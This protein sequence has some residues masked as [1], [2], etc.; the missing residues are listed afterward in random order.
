M[1]VIGTVALIL[2]TLNSLVLVVA[3]REI[4]I[5]RASGGRGR[6]GL[7]LNDLVPEFATST[8]GGAP[9][10]AK[11]V[12]N[13]VLL[14]LSAQCNACMKLVEQIRAVPDDARPHGLVVGVT[15]RTSAAS[16]SPLVRSLDFIPPARVFLD[17]RREIFHLLEAP[18]TPFAYVINAE[19]RV[20]GSGVPIDL[21]EL[22]DM[23]RV[24]A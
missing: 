9:F 1:E 24:L 11:D 20:R 3:L 5:L 23:S 13:S 18:L 19:G 2:A 4:G 16:D 14:L 21:A 8:I 7:K 15:S 12:R 17:N 22:R 6:S 10:S